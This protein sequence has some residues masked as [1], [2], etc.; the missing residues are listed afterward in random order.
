MYL[1]LQKGLFIQTEMDRE[2]LAKLKCKNCCTCN[3]YL[4]KYSVKY[5]SIYLYINE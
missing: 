4:L 3:C 2:V 5:I 1:S